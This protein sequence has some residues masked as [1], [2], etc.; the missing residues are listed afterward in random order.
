MRLPRVKPAHNPVRL[1]DGTIHLG[2]PLYGVAAQL[3]DTD[4]TVWRLI[5]LLDGAR[6]LDAVVAEIGRTDPDLDERSIRDS[7]ATLIEMGF[8]EDAGA[9]VPATLSAAEID[10]YASS[11]RY[12]SWTDTAPRPSPYEHQ[13]LLKQSTVTVLGLGGTGGAAAMSLA[14]VGVGALRCVD[15]DVVEPGNLNR[16]IL[17]DEDDVGVPKVEAALRRLRRM[18]RHVDV[19]GTRLRVGSVEDLAPLMDADMFLLCADAPHPEIELWTNEAALRTR[20]P[21]ILAQY[22]GP[23][24][25]TGLFLPHRTPC[26]RCA[27][28]KYPNLIGGPEAVGLQSLYRTPVQA[29]IAP[30]AVLS[31]QIAALEAVYHLTGMP[32]QT[33]GRIF[34]QNLVV[35]DTSFFVD[36]EFWPDCPDC[37]G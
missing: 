31:G 29:V 37:G 36:L 9:P 8:V 24:T 13:R 18:N 6:E 17:Y 35:Y 28:E 25:L 11:A 33:A 30:S 7:V 20:T 16:Q 2:G 12:F 19:S 34:R 4:G 14:A 21:W 10:R 23:L 26:F 22:V 5:G 32:T 3:D 1:P 15:F 27:A